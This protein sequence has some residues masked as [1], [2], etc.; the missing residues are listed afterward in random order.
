[1]HASRAFASD[2]CFVLAL[3]LTAV[4]WATALSVSPLVLFPAW[5][6]AAAGALLMPNP[7]RCLVAIGLVTAPMYL[8]GLLPLMAA[9]LWWHW[10]RGRAS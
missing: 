6:L 1:M 9:L 5:G 8:V 10:E 2:L 3:P 7:R 4:A